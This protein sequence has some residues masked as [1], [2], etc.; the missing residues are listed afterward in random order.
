MHLSFSILQS[1]TIAPGVSFLRSS[2]WAPNR[3]ARAN[4]AP[5]ARGEILNRRH[6]TQTFHCISRTVEG[7]PGHFRLQESMPDD[8]KLDCAPSKRKTIT[9]TP[10]AWL[11]SLGHPTGFSTSEDFNKAKVIQAGSPS[12]ANPW[13]CRSRTWPSSNITNARANASLS[14]TLATNST[15]AHNTSAPRWE[16][17]STYSLPC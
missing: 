8:E 9:W 13:D 7:Q 1:E 17:M 10:K 5:H 11:N 4:G 16:H 3:D 12:T 14:S 6:H 2:Q 15:A